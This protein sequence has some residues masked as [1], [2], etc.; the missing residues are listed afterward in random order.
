MN[1]EQIIAMA[2]EAGKYADEKYQLEWN[3]G[4]GASWQSIRDERFASL[5][6]AHE[7]EECAKVCVG[8]EQA[9]QEYGERGS[10]SAC[11]AAIR[12]RKP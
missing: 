6:A 2:R 12:A 5:V 9:A 7:R 11:A 8:I 1:R 3:A 10:A 4:G